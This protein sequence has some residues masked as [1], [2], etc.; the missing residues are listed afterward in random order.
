M[1]FYNIPKFFEFQTCTQTG[2]YTPHEFT[3]TMN[4]SMYCNGNVFQD[5]STISK[6]FEV[7]KQMNETTARHKLNIAFTN[8]RLNENYQV[9]ATCANFIVNTI[10]PFIF[11]ITLNAL[12]VRALKSRFFPVQPPTAPAI[13]D[14][15]DGMTKF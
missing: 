1:D 2:V 11:I 9:Y 6:I 10:G 15:I 4:S 14:R 12:I 13:T 3:A 5:H 7:P 8:L